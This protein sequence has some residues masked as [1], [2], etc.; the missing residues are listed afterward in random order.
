MFIVKAA[1]KMRAAQLDVIAP[2]R[3]MIQNC[4]FGSCSSSCPAFL[5]VSTCLGG[6]WPSHAT[7][8]I[9]NEQARLD[10]VSYLQSSGL[11]LLNYH[12]ARLVTYIWMFGSSFSSNRVMVRATRRSEATRR[13]HIS[14]SGSLLHRLSSFDLYVHFVGYTL[15]KSG[16]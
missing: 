12:N 2:R 15:A 5:R 9:R 10:R 1:G 3:L 13:I 6:R 16:N 11:T 4:M 7:S 14:K 8:Q